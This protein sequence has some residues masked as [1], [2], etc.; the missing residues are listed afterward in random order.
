MNIVL[1]LNKNQKTFLFKDDELIVTVKLNVI[2][3]DS[4][5][6]AS[7]LFIGFYD[8]D[9]CHFTITRDGTLRLI[10]EFGEWAGVSPDNNIEFKICPVSRT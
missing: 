9:P 2:K 3:L 1:P 4:G 5:Y 8:N 6:Y 7:V 10:Q